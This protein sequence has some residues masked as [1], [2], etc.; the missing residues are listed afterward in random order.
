MN[1]SRSSHEICGL[2][3]C[4]VDGFKHRMPDVAYKDRCYFL[5]HYHSDHYGGLAAHWKHGKIYCSNTTANLIC[6]VLGVNPNIV[7][8]VAVGESVRIKDA[9]VTFMDANHCPGAVILLFELNSGLNHLHTGDLRFCPA[10]KLYPAIQ[11]VKIDRL[12]LDTTYAH[13]K[14]TFMPQDESITKIVKLARE[15]IAHNPEDGIIFISAY[16]LGK[17]RVIFA[18]SDA[19]NQSVYMDADKIMIIS[20]IEGGL[21]RVESGRFTSD[22]RAARIHVCKMGFLGSLFPY[23]KPN[24]DGIRQH[25]SELNNCSAEAGIMKHFL[26][27]EHSKMPLI[28]PAAA[29]DNCA[30]IA[31][32]TAEH[33]S[34]C[35]KP[36]IFRKAIAFI[37]TGWADNGNFNKQHN[38]MSEEDITVCTVPY[39]EHSNYTEL[40]EFV[41]FLKPREVI[42]TV[43]SDVRI[44]HTCYFQ[45]SDNRRAIFFVFIL[46]SD[47][48][49]IQEKNRLF[50]LDMFRNCV[51]RVSNMRNFIAK[52]S[53][54]AQSPVPRTDSKSI[55][56]IGVALSCGGAAN[57][58]G[59][60]AAAGASAAVLEPANNTNYNGGRIYLPGSVRTDGAG[61]SKRSSSS[62]AGSS[63]SSKVNTVAIDLCDSDSDRDVKC[64]DREIYISDDLRA[65]KIARTNILSHI[66]GEG[67]VDP[68]DGNVLNCVPGRSSVDDDG[69]VNFG[70]VG[71]WSCVVCTYRHSEPGCELFLQCAVCCSPRSK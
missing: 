20:Q 46:L 24:F 28:L 6:N 33:S 13:P 61:L 45:Y 49:G 14:H 52:M 4:L 58:A 39:S 9:C 34:K 2:P 25:L 43:Y 62:S 55:Q 17:E 36:I 22:P 40:V 48:I 67:L 23:F 68:K 19:V 60:G 44:L 56:H 66:S 57:S 63:S 12:Y 16:N 26:H 35:N 51:D 53:S 15:F 69:D 21:E 27:T 38:V 11:N 1:S 42:P 8:R 41:T 37:P 18:L 29:A 59:K 64:D 10:M 70:S 71:G 30:T 31:N 7:Q 3:H 5:T 65:S 50:I 54:Q 32:N 47:M